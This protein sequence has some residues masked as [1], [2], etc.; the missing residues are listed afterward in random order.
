VKYVPNDEYLLDRYRIKV[1][2]GK[3]KKEDLKNYVRQKPNKRILGIRFH[4]GM[5]N[6]SNKNKEKGFSN[7]LRT[8]GEE[9]VIFDE[10]LTNK[11]KQQLKSYLNNKG[12]YNSVVTDTVQYRK[13]RARI[14]YK[15]K[16]NTPYTIKQVSYICNDSNLAPIILPDTS[17]SLINSG[18]NFDLDILQEE[19]KRIEV[20]LKNKGY[21]NF[22]KEY[23]NFQ[24]DSSA[25]NLNVAL[26]LNIRKAHKKTPDG[27]VYVE[28]KKFKI[29]KIYVFTNFDQKVA[30]KQK[31]FYYD[32]IDTTYVNGIYFI[33]KG[34]DNLNKRVIHQSNFIE[35]GDFYSLDNLDKTY[36]HLNSLR[37]FKI[38]NIHFNEVDS[39][40]EDSTDVKFLDCNIQLTKYYLQSYTVELQGTNSY[41]NIGAGGSF[42]Y[43]HRSLFGGAEITDFR[44]NGSI[45]TIDE[46]SWGGNDYTTEIGANV[47]VSIPKF[48]LPIF[49][50]EKFSKKFSPKTQ[51]SGGYNFQDRIEYRRSIANLS[52]GYSWDG[53]K[54]LK[55]FVKFVELNAVNVDATPSFKSYIDS[56]YLKSSYE[57]HLVS[58][59]N[60]SLT[61]N[62]QDIKKSRDFYFFKMN[63]EF[64]GNVL[65]VASELAGSNK[66][67]GSYE[68]FGIPFSQYFKVDFDFR[69]YDI[70]DKTNTIVYRLFVGAGIPYGNS[71]VLPF[72]K[73]YF[74]GGAN[75][76]RAWNVRSV[77]PGSY[78]GGSQTRFPNQS[79]DLK[80]E[81]NLEYRFKLFWLLEGAF[82]IDAG[83]VWSLKSDEFEG[84]LFRKNEF[85]KEFAVGSGFGTRFDFSFLI[86]RL[87]LGVKLRD[88]A[89]E[90]G[91]RWIVGNRSLNWQ[92]DFT[93]NIGIGYPF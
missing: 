4:L 93:I 30:L 90:E 36:K 71:T 87:D 1:T 73:M 11:S 57:N 10:F 60:Y 33:S 56:T 5:Y 45:E 29:R 67:D 35:S 16:A 37:I 86:F 14:L 32:D 58:V 92:D 28:H 7:W 15:V 78:S 3:I 43:Q 81:A 42:L 89:L 49:K 51:I 62:N 91:Q 52:Y 40:S 2:E 34:Q 8:I 39:A 53:N 38:I 47:T 88:P 18:D 66:V 64:S 84:G 44:I 21:Y 69:Y 75:S 46:Q 12:Y 13:R 76:I 79:G 77:G 50:A 23:I 85:Y 61:F 6:L 55:H 82:F 72:E 31:E 9:P 65:S 68:I 41:G 48:I 54:Y 19:R 83:N 27:V 22:N 59:T 26:N 80:L 17:N 74:A 25:R 63:T 24:A 20:K 70:V